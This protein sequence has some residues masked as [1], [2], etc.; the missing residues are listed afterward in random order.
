MCIIQCVLVNDISPHPMPEGMLGR[1]DSTRTHV[2]SIWSA[3]AFVTCS[4]GGGMTAL[5]K[6]I[7]PSSLKE[8]VLG[9]C[10]NSIVLGNFLR[11]V[12]PGGIK[13]NQASGSHL[14][15]SVILSQPGQ[16]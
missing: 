3:I 7:A 9:G 2:P 6:G 5:A 12:S 1:S 10:K 16:A 15:C 14:R 11:P 8:I 13:C 4:A